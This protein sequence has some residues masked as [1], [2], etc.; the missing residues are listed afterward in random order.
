MPVCKIA[1]S[2]LWYIICVY[3]SDKNILDLSGL[4]PI[5]WYGGWF[6]QGYLTSADA[7]SIG[8]WNFLG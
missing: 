5:T 8:G 2:A 1:V 4:L 3:M 6:I 7:F